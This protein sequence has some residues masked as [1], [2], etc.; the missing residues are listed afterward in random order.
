MGS[1]AT[2]VIRGPLDGMRQSPITKAPLDTFY[3]QIPDHL[4]GAGTPSHDLSVAGTCALGIDISLDMYRTPWLWI[5]D[6]SGLLRG[7]SK[8]LIVNRLPS[9]FESSLPTSLSSGSVRRRP[10]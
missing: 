3:H 4:A 8:G 2:A 1:I 10:N 7:Y 9:K 6:L 5:Y